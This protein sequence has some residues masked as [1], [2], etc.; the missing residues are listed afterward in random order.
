MFAWQ[1]SMLTQFFV[2]A[3]YLVHGLLYS[4]NMGA[5]SHVMQVSQPVYVAGS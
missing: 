5:Y 4:H 3:Y 2:I 1:H